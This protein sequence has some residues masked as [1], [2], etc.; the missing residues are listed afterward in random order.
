MEVTLTQLIQM[1]PELGSILR[2]DVR[3]GRL[4]AIR[5]RGVAGRPYVLSTEDLEASGR[6]EY[7]E[8]AE[9]AERTPASMTPRTKRMV[10]QAMPN[11]MHQGTELF[12]IMES[13]HMMLKDLVQ[14]LTEEMRNRYDR[15]DRQN[16]QMQELSYKLGQAHQQIARLERMLA[17]R[18]F[19]R[20]DEAN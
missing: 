16:V 15:L 3:S 7:R 12:D 8:L 11:M 17:E 2:D 20:V 9:L 4:K 1:A 18:S 10:S 19:G 14:V 6:P 13:Q 5:K